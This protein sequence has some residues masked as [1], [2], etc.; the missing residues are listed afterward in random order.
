MKNLP[1]GHD[2]FMGP[3][4]RIGACCCAGLLALAL[5]PALWPSSAAA[6][7]C[8]DPFTTE[9]ITGTGIDVGQVT[10]CNDAELL[11][12]TY[13]TTFPWCV[14]K[15]DLHV[16]IVADPNDPAAGIPQTFLGTPRWRKFDYGDRHECLGEVAEPMLKMVLWSAVVCRKESDG[17]V[18]CDVVPRGTGPPERPAP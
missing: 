3:G 18:P 4:S 16:A 17:N 5:L 7:T 1:I 8:D 9:L 2:G 10:V 6:H 15:T 11:T 12:V 13:E 14:R